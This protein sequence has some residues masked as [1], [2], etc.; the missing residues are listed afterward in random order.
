MSLLSDFCAIDENIAKAAILVIFLLSF[1]FFR[2]TVNKNDIRTEEQK[3]ERMKKA[4]EY[5]NKHLSETSEFF[6]N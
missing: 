5:C 3:R 2:Y 1:L 4:E 6:N